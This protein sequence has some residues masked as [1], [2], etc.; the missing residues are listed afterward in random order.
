MTPFALEYLCDPVD[1]SGLSLT[2]AEYDLYGQIVYGRLTSAS[3]R[4]YPIVRGIPRFVE[5]VGLAE[6]VASFG[7]EWNFFNFTAFKE[8]WLNHTVRN[9]FGD[10]EVFRNKIIVDAG[11]GSGAQTL[12]MLESGAKHLFMLDLSNSVDDVVQRNLKPSGY[13]NY[14]VIQCSIDA[15]PLRSRSVSGIVIC[16]NVIQHTPSVEKTATALYEIVADD[17]EFVFNCYPKNDQG[18]LRWIRFHL[19]YKPLRAVLSR[20]P[21]WVI[22]AYARLMGILR[23]IPGVGIVLEKL[24]FCVQGDVPNTKGALDRIRRCYRATVLNTFDGYGSHA[25]QHHKTDEEILALVRALQP[26]GTKVLNMDKYFLRP[27]PIGCALRIYR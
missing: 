27:A 8:H 7:D 26:D 13:T 1:H 14:D 2:D 3:G 21:F 10:I 4:E 20:M 24:N 15:P 19:I 17:G 22:L 5:D 25:Y 9:T 16:H 23:L 6:T 18:L 12:W 11:G